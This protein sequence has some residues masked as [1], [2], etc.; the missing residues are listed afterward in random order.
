MGHWA[1]QFW[2]LDF[3]FWIGSQSKIQNL[4]F[5]PL[6]PL[7]PPAPCS[8]LPCSLLPAPCFKTRANDLE[9]EKTF[10]LELMRLVQ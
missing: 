2:I 9:E 4:K 5:F 1:I 7:S 8:L 6:S 10:P 3:K